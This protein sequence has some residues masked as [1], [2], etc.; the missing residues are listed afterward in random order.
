VQQ[1]ETT[2]P[3]IKQE[4]SNETKQAKGEDVERE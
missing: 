1:K 3:P 2:L 4:Q